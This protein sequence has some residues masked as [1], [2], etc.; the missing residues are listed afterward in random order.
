MTHSQLLAA[1][2]QTPA[3]SMQCMQ[4]NCAQLRNTAIDC[5]A[6]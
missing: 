2:T 6:R 4:D 3:A 5:L 1:A